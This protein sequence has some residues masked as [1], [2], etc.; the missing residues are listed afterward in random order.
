MKIFPAHN[1]GRGS[2]KIKTLIS[3][4]IF[5]KTHPKRVFCF[6][7]ARALSSAGLPENISFSWGFFRF[8]KKCLGKL[9]LGFRSVIKQTI[10]S[11][12]G[13]VPAHII[14]ES[15]DGRAK[16]NLN[17]N[18]LVN[19]T[20]QLAARVNEILNDN[21]VSFIVDGKLESPTLN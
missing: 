8:P 16:M 6:S 7:Q 2:K 13:S 15:E 12:R 4:G 18:Y 14:F 9:G 17:E 5:L 19:P 3:I 20:P 1:C 10:L 11:Y 21:S